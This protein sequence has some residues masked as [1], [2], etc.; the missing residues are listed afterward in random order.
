MSKKSPLPYLDHFVFTKKTACMQR[1]GDLVRTGHR[2]YVRGMISLEKAGFLAA[3]FE[4]KFGIERTKLE[5]SRGRKNG[6]SSTR[7]FMLKAHAE[8]SEL[9]WILLHQPGDSLDTGEKWRDALQDRIELTGYELV[10]LVKPNE[11]N[12]VWTWRYSRTRHDELRNSIVQAIRTR[13]DDELR[14]LIYMIWRTPGFYGGREQV[15]KFK[16]LILGEW[17][18]S[19][20]SG[21]P[22]IPDRLGY[23]RRIADKG[24]RLSELRRAEAKDG[25]PRGLA[26]K[27]ANLGIEKMSTPPTSAL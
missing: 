25:S 24:A 8:S 9:E 12:P 18:R 13:R 14:Q 16:E 22:D 10:R 11:K 6:E 23:V 5:A 1:I 4:A 2:C 3:K 26:E 19:S 7:L 15:K 17:K 27:S 20:R 21:K